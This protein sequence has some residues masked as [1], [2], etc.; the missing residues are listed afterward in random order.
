VFQSGFGDI[1]VKLQDYWC[2][3]FLAMLGGVACSLI[4]ARGRRYSPFLI[5][6]LLILLVYPWNE[7]FSKNYNYAEHS[8]AEEWGIDYGLAMR[9]FWITT[10][11]SRW[12]EGP[13]GIGLINFMRNEIHQRR[14][15]AGTHVY[16]LRTISPSWATLTATA[17]SP[18]SMTTRSFMKF[19]QWMSGG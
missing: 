17:S 2:P 6:A 13:D 14:V 15:T 9:G 12:T 5:V 4:W 18:T 8:I 10:G 3:F 1:G 19:R 11:D 16:A 7:R